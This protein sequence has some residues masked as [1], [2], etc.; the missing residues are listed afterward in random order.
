MAFLAVE[1]VKDSRTDADAVFTPTYKY[2]IWSKVIQRTDAAGGQVANFKKT[3]LGFQFGARESSDAALL[4]AGRC[5]EHDRACAV[6]RP[7]RQ[8]RGSLHHDSKQV[9]QRDPERARRSLGC[10]R[11]LDRLGL[12]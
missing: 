7:C 4:L 3:T 6:V 10:G 9:Y 11:G 5:F 12:V 1:Y 8:F 2:K